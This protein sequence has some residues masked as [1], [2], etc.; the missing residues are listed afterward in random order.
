M[1]LSR[2]AAAIGVLVLGVAGATEA[3][4]ALLGV[5]AGGNTNAQPP[6]SS[7]KGTSATVPS[8]SWRRADQQ[9]G[10]AHDAGDGGGGCVH[11][12]LH[13]SARRAVH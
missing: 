1:G 7:A 8:L 4:G 10:Q 3:N 9:R 12:V 5:H 13:F 2:L 11:M 6:G